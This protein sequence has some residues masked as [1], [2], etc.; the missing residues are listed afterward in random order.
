MNRES[1]Y[2]TRKVA[3]QAENSSND[4]VWNET[5]DSIFD[6]EG[7]SK[8]SVYELEEEHGSIEGWTE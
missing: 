7:V 8:V 1:Y 2:Y 5:P 6:D 3:M 4:D